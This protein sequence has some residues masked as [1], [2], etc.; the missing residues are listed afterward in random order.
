MAETSHGARIIMA[1]PAIS[2]TTLPVELELRAVERLWSHAFL[3]KSLLLI[4]LGVFWQ[5][6]ARVLDNSL[7]FPT[8]GETLA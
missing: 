1:P 8:L 4:L 6:Y 2:A 3:R 5:V 7:L